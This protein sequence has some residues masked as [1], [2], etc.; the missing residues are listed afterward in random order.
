MKTYTEEAKEETGKAPACTGALLRI[1]KITRGSV[2]SEKSEFYGCAQYTVQLQIEQPPGS[3][4][5]ST[6]SL[7]SA[8]VTRSAGVVCASYTW[9][10]SGVI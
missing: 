7:Y 8:S 2:K 6:R 9:R 10:V 5:A 1:K 3:V 4:V